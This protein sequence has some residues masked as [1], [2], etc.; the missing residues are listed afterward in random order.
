MQLSQ[1]KAIR[2]EDI[3]LLGIPLTDDELFNVEERP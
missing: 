2:L 3:L 1:L